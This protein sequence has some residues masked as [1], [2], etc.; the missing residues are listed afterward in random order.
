MDFG[1]DSWE[2]YFTL[3]ADGTYSLTAEAEKF[4]QA[5]ESA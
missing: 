4:K 1:Y 5:I 2:N 3:M